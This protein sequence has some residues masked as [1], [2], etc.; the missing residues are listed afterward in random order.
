MVHRFGKQTHA[1]N[2]NY[3]LAIRPENSQGE[4]IAGETSVA[5]LSPK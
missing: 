2:S 3:Q 1:V 5:L 4:R